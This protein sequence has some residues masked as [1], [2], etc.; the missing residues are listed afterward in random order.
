MYDRGTYLYKNKI[1]I[2]VEGF[3]EGTH[4]LDVK[5]E[6]PKLD[7]KGILEQTCQEVKEIGEKIYALNNKCNRQGVKRFI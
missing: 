1:C 2:D 6:N 3:I 5:E 7:V 4:N